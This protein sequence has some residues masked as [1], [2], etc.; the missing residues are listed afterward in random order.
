MESR[1][2]GPE[3]ND[4]DATGGTGTGTGTVVKARPKTKKPSM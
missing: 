1:A 2:S 4:D 3:R